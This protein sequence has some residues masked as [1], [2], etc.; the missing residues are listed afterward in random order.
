VIPLGIGAIVFACVFGG[1][2]GG[3]FLRTVV[4]EH[5]L[6]K[7]TEDA[8]KLGMGMVATLAALVIGLLV[9]SAKS[10]FDT[11][12][13]ELRHFAANLILLDRQLVHYGPEASEARDLLRRYTVFKLDST[14]PS[15]ASHPVDNSDGWMLLE[16]VQDKLRALAPR[17]DAQR[18]LQAR[19]LQISSDLA[20]TRW[21]LD[22]QRGTSIRVPFLVILVFWLTIIFTT[23]GVFAPHHATMIAALFVCA[24]SVAGALFLIL[25]MDRPFGGLIHLPSA[26]M[27]EALAH[28][29]Q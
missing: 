4:P 10:S 21:L 9:A 12:D 23:F 16:D 7:E 3:M 6:T 20:S 22:V 2:L 25:E 19:A 28:L 1:A 14:W 27:R 13:A 24:L 18:W 5:H 8:V 15:E 11:K 17:D 26:P 29:S